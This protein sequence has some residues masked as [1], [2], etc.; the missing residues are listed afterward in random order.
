MRKYLL[1]TL[2]LLA[3]IVPAFAG[4]FVRMD[5][6]KDVL[7]YVKTNSA[8]TSICTHVSTATIIPGKHRII[9]YEV[10]PIAASAG[11]ITVALYDNETVALAT[12]ATYSDDLFAET[13]CANTTS[14]ERSFPYPKRLDT[15]LSILQGAGTV[16]T[17]Y[18]ERYS[19]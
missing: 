18:Y 10:S 9:G 14:A 5:E 12:T 6:N 4:N 11:T 13:V 2:I 17:I 1:T 7:V 16:V 3:M 8:A 15:G 19:P